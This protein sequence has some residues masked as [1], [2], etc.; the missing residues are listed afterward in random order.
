MVS[1]IRCLGSELLITSSPGWVNESSS[2]L[3]LIFPFICIRRK[4]HAKTVA[5]AENNCCQFRIVG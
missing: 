4:G 1:G 5:A 2:H 3:G